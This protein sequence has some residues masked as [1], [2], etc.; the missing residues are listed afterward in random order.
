MT[1]L[2]G[3][4]QPRQPTILAAFDS[5]DG[6]DAAIMYL[7]AEAIPRAQIQV[8]GA[9]TAREMAAA[10]VASSAAPATTTAEAPTPGAATPDAARDDVMPDGTA[11]TEAEERNLRTLR[12]STVGV[13]AAFAGAGVVLA[14]GGAALPAVAAA[15]AA[16]AGAGGLSQFAPKAAAGAAA[17]EVASVED[18]AAAVLVV[19]PATVDQAERAR[20]VLGK[21]ATLRVWEEGGD[22]AAA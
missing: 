11:L 14:T 8:R 18:E 12:T 17:P 7:E 13:A 3:Q 19:A 22:G 9:A 4:P 10:P 2:S 21:V 5:M 1:D 20:G 15:V 6:V 16:G